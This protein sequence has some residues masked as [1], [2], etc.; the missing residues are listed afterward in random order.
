MQRYAGR[1]KFLSS[2]TERYSLHLKNGI[3]IEAH[4]DVYEQRFNA[5]LERLGVNSKSWYGDDAV[6]RNRAAEVLLFCRFADHVVRDYEGGRERMVGP[7]PLR[8]YQ[9]FACK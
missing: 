1:G 4:P 8:T 5:Y 6:S 9:A 3:Y 7:L 2:L